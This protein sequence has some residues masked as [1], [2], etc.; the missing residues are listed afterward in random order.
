MQW[1]LIPKMKNSK[2]IVILQHNGGQLCNQLWNFVSIYAYCLE[3]GYQC[4]NYSFFEYSK[5]FN[6]P[7]RN[8]FIKFFYFIP[9]SFSSHFLPFRVVRKIS[10]IWYSFYVAWTRFFK[11]NQIIYSGNSFNEVKDFYFLPPTRKSEE[12]LAN[13]ERKEDANIIYFDGWLFRNPE[14]LSKYRKEVINYFKPKEVYW[15]SAESFVEN[16]RK[17]YPHLVGVHIRQRVTGDGKE[18]IING[19]KMCISKEE[20]NLVKKTLENYLKKFK[21]D[22]SQ[23]CFVICSNR[24]FDISPLK[25]LNIVFSGKS[26]IEDLYILAKTDLIIGCRSTFGS[27]AAWHGNIPHFTILENGEIKETNLLKI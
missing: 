6:I 5:Y 1:E 16:L 12:K 25:D 19:T 14:G 3:K 24:K 8:R 13:L 11:K 15:K 18:V 23:A 10:R 22:P 4:Q 26:Q 7:I 21:K 27:F 9:F 2:K 20:T 17:N